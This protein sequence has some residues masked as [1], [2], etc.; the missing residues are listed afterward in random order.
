MKRLLVL[1]TF[2]AALSVTQVNAQQGGD[3]QA[4]MQRMK[5][6]IKPQLMD[7][8]KLTDAQAD[9]VIDINFAMRQQMRQLR[10]LNEDE[11]KKKMD[12]LR[13]DINKQY[14]AIPLTD[15]Q[16][17]AVNDFFDEMRKN[18]QQQ[19]QQGGGNGQ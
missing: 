9:K 1:F 16:V 8:A 13:E 18:M 6:Q 19:R 15:D 17:K 11:R 14:K 12:E 7:K 2:L 4:R 5:E 10:D 3:P